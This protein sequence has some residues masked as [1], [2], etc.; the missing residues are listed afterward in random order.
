MMMSKIDASPPWIERIIY[1]TFIDIWYLNE[2]IEK[3]Q[4]FVDT[5]F[6][7]KSHNITS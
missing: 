6:Q 1:W 2:I 4:K 5:N 7:W 3:K